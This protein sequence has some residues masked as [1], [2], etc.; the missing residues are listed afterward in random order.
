MAFRLALSESVD[1]GLRR[2]VNEEIES[3]IEHLRK[4]DDSLQGDGIHEA[5]KSIKKV[6]AIVRLLMPGLGA[7]GFRENRALRDTGRALSKLR[8]AAAL[9]ET[10][11]GLSERYFAEPAMEQLSVVRSALRRNLERTVRS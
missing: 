3:A 6:R 11:E 10:V 4:E 7:A 9:I 5:R 8:D 2:I 1:K